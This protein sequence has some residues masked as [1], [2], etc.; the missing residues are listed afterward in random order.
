MADFSIQAN[1]VDVEQIMRQIRARIRE[2]RGVDYTEEEI[3]TLASVKLEKF[4]DPSKVRSDLLEEY[5]KRRAGPDTSFPPPPPNFAFEDRTVYDS[6]RTAS[7]RVIM[8]LRRLLNPVLKLFINPNPIIQVLHMQAEINAHNARQFE[9][10]SAHDELYYE[11]VHN[12]VLEVTRLGIEVKNVKMR[13]ESISGRLDFDER[14]GR[15]LEG[16]VQYKPG[17]GSAPR[18][19]PAPRD[20]GPGPDA[21]ER[22]REPEPAAALS[23]APGAESGR[24]SRRRRRR[25]GGRGQR[26]G[27][28]EQGQAGQ[29]QEAAQPSEPESDRFEFDGAEPPEPPGGAPERIEPRAEPAGSAPA[30]AAAPKDDP[31]GRFDQ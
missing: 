9:R 5:R 18:P 7:G 27:M 28:P 16:V 3:R 17:A 14:R 29:D 6:A 8:F 1:A 10:V 22:E 11:L 12:L 31:S 2:K 26:P 21:R 19:A 25:R 4:L 24:S 23:A 30:D 13:A 20:A 15:A